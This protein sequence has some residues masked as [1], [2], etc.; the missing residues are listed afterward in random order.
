M[1]LT[2]AAIQPLIRTLLIMTGKMQVRASEWN[3]S[4]ADPIKLLHGSDLSSAEAWL[5]DEDSHPRIRL[6][7]FN[8]VTSPHPGRLRRYLLPLS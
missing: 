2:S 1:Y 7:S 6:Q 3:D 8:A 5:A 4:E